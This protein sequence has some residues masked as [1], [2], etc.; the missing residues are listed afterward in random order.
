MT[1]QGTSRKRLRLDAIE[2]IGVSFDGSGRLEGQ[3]RAPAALREAGLAAVL[4]QRASVTPDVVVSEP[5]PT[6]GPAGFVN[7]RALLEMVDLLHGRVR[8]AVARGRFPLLYGADCAVLLAAVPALA[9]VLGGAGLLFSECSRAHPDPSP[10]ARRDAQPTE[11]RVSL[12]RQADAT[13]R[14]CSC[15]RCR[16]HR[17]RWR[18]RR[19]VCAAC[20]PAGSR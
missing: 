18:R 11:S 7:E 16:P 13:R 6:R 19:P 10:S 12:T 9:E 15:I 2:L 5:T 14:G 8:A 4:Q 17:G 3:A 20:G 1:E